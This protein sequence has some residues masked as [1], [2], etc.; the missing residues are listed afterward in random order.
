MT[1]A[2]YPETSLSIQI[3]DMPSGLVELA[4]GKSIIDR[5]SPVN[6]GQL[7]LNYGGGGHAAAGTCQ[8]ES[9]KVDQ[10]IEELLAYIDAQNA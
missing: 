10:V 9:D 3:S 5:S 4:V 1:Y 6:I 8:V 7:M 2:L